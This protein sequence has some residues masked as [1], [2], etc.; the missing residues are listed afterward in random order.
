[1]EFPGDRPLLRIGELSRRL[2]VSDHVLRAWENRYGLLQPVRSP[3]GFRLYSEADERRV[4]RMQAY[5][6]DGLSAAEAARAT[7]GGDAITSLGYL[8]GPRLTKS[9]GS[10]PSARLRQA[11]DAFDVPAAQAAQAVLDRLLA[12]LSVPAVLRD[13]VLPYLA[14]LGERWQ[15]GT[16]SVALEHF[17]SNLIRGRARGAGPRLGQRGLGMSRISL[18]R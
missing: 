8:T 2:G 17:A 9:A 13:V 11:L 1:M 10:E 15:G 3:G 14:D 16:A 7:L 6:A 5:L 4:R 12:D 18:C